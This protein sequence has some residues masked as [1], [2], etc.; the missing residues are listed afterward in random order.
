LSLDGATIREIPM[1]FLAGF[2]GIQ[3]DYQS[4]CLRPEIGWAVRRKTDHDSAVGADR[5]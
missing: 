2:V 4:R 1:E 3:Q 5:S